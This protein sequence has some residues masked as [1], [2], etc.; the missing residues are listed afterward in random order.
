MYAQMSG[1]SMACP[2]VAGVA[3]KVWAHFPQCTNK[4]IRQAMI[5][6]AKLINGSNTC[7]ISQGHGLVQA[8][9]MF[10]LIASSG[11]VAVSEGT[12]L[13]GCLEKQNNPTPQTPAP[14]A[15]P[16]TPAPVPT[17]RFQFNPSL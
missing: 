10:D 11:C 4:Q 7:D 12:G 17:R 14:I 1:T 15:T 8:K 2:H 3:A 5:Q 6:T 9:S 16:Q 13:G